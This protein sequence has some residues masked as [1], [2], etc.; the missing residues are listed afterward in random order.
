MMLSLPSV[1]TLVLPLL[2]VLLID[3][4]V[5][6]SIETG[7]PHS[8]VQ[9]LTEDNVDD[10][11]NDP[12]NGLW[13]LKF[14]APWCGHCKKLAPTLN[15]MAPYLAGKLSIGKID[16]TD[17]LAKPI[18]D[19]H[20]IKG[21]PTLKIYRDGD[22]F[23]YPGKRDADSMITF[24]EK[25]S[26]P[27]VKVV[28]SYDDALGDVVR[29]DPSRDVGVGDGV[30]FIAYDGSAAKLEEVGE[31]GADERGVKALEAL[32]ASSVGLQVFG[33]VARKLQAE[34][35][36]GVL[37]A[38]ATAD[39]LEKFGIKDGHKGPVLMK[40]EE[41]VP[42]VV[43]DGP[44]NSMEFLDFVKLNNVALITELAGNNF[45]AMSKKGKPLAIA[46]VDGQDTVKT[47]AYLQEAREYAQNGPD[48][49]NYM[50]CRMDGKTWKGFLDQFPIDSDNLPTILLLDST[51]KQYWHNDT[52]S[53]NFGEFLEAVKDGKVEVQ[54]LNPRQR[55]GFIASVADFAT[56]HLYIIVIII[57]LLVWFMV[58]LTI[59]TGREEAKERAVQSKKKE[60]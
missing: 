7:K 33:Q 16:C 28:S 37:H 51:K 2:H 44:L 49:A 59:V 57:C 17:S 25:M 60:E 53:N 54:I 52:V 13:L 21:Y 23:D 43:Y 24:A 38:G 48:R 1:A 20:L 30:G 36:F 32:L 14:Y 56:E 55:R 5:A 19:K 12:A 4:S 8:T 6:T 10:A 29:T 3:Q 46:V 18:C 35:S 39:E 26:M 22:F 34:A 42:T 47:E 11:L 45:R 58:Y 50:F 31:I 15:K 40:V 41:N 9:I 27:A